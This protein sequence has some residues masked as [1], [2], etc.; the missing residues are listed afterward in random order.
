MSQR[1]PLQ[2]KAACRRKAQRLARPWEP[3]SQ[4]R[5]SAREFLSLIGVKDKNNDYRRATAW[6]AMV[7]VGDHNERIPARLKEPFR[8]G[9]PRVHAFKGHGPVD[10]EYRIPVA[11]LDE[12]YAAQI[13]TIL[14]LRNGQGLDSIIGPKTMA[15]LKFL[16]RT[17]GNSP[18]QIVAT[19]VQRMVETMI[20]EVHKHPLPESVGTS[21]A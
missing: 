9:V 6:L 5:L 21:A 18:S 11:S 14:S 1:D 19:S 16:S 17:T 13:Q 4:E 8:D 2:M 7:V 20:R 12:K 15:Q 10:I 3:D